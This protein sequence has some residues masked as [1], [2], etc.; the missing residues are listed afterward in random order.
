MAHIQYMHSQWV[1]CTVAMSYRLQF[2]VRPPHFLS[3]INTVVMDEAAAVLREV[4]NTL[5]RRAILMAPTSG[6]KKT[7]AHL[8]F[9]YSEEGGL[10][11][12]LNL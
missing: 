2:R 12:L 7:L 8:L 9:R 6:A 5:I 11:P 1:G 4:I 10:H 3:I